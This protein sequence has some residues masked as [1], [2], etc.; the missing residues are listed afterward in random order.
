M[1]GDITQLKT[2]FIYQCT[3]SRVFWDKKFNI[4]NYNKRVEEILIWKFNIK[5]SNNK[6]LSGHE[7]PHLF[8]Y[9]DESNTGLASV[10]EENGKLNM[11]KKNFNFIEATKSSTWKELEA[12]RCFLDSV[13]SL[14]SSKHVNGTQITTHLLLQQN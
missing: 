5:Q 2:R 13:K 12:I 9:S 6:S 11:C 4:S 14:L 1:L 7:T 8:I 10:Y 3:E